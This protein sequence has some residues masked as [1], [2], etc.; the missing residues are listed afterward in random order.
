MRDAASNQYNQWQNSFNS[1]YQD[2]WS[3][4]KQKRVLELFTS[5]NEGFNSELKGLT[6]EELFEKQKD[7]KE[8]EKLSGIKIVFEYYRYS[9]LATLREN[10]L[11]SGPSPLT[12]EQITYVKSFEG[13][14]VLL[15][16]DLQKVANTIENK[17]SPFITFDDVVVDN[18]PPDELDED[19]VDSDA[20][21]PEETLTEDEKADQ[22]VQYEINMNKGNRSRLMRM[23]EGNAMF[24]ETVLSSS[25]LNSEFET[26]SAHQLPNY[27]LSYLEDVIK[28]PAALEKLITND[29][30]LMDSYIGQQILNN[31]EFRQMLNRLRIDRID[32]ITARKLTELEDGKVVSN[33]KLQVNKRD[34]I[35]YGKFQDREFILTNI[36]MYLEDQEKIL[37]ENGENLIHTRHLIRVIES[38]S[39]GDTISMPVIATVNGAGDKVKLS[40]RAKEIFLQEFMA[41]LRKL[42]AADKKVVLRL[43]QS[44]VDQKANKS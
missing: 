21:E 26:V 29:P 15:L 12:K 22:A 5:I 35:T 23:A 16:E 43:V 44:M 42:S 27:H 34:G 3:A 20:N 28:N 6:D 1:I 11:K 9:V 39:T 25:W 24:D 40:T 37:K 10:N 2:K 32:G 31:G 33:N 8:L 19:N 13:V 18:T 41:E 7:L 4:R 38:K 30:F 17:E 36:L 14:P